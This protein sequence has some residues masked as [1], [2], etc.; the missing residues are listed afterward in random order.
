MS[1]RSTFKHISVALAIAFGVAIAFCAGGVTGFTYGFQTGF[2]L[3]RMVAGGTVLNALDVEGEPNK[4]ILEGVLD[5]ALMSHH[6]RQ[7][8]GGAP[9]KVF[10]DDA[11][12]NSLEIMMSKVAEYRHRHQTPPSQ[13]EAPTLPTDAPVPSGASPLNGVAPDDE[14]KTPATRGP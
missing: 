12:N 7:T 11:T 1:K 14:P 10:S 4:V 9:F 5:E 3:A 6:T 13:S 2:D 8:L